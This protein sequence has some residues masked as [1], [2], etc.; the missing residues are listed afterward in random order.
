MPKIRSKAQWKMFRAM[1]SRGEMSRAE[2]EKRSAG[3][4]YKSLPARVAKK[5]KKKSKKA[6]RKKK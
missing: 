4:N 2:W 5:K 1:M 6:G 3:V